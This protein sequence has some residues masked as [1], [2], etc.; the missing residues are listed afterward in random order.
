MVKVL[1]VDDSPVARQF[2]EHVLQTDPNLRVVGKVSSGQEAIDF[3]AR[4]KPDVV[5]M[6]IHMPG[7]DGFEATRRIMEHNPVPIVMVSACYEPGEVDKAFRALDE[8]ALALLARP[9]GIG[10]DRHEEQSRAIC[11]TVR[12]MAGVKV[13]RRMRRT[14]RPVRPLPPPQ[15][16]EAETAA[17]PYQVLAL[18]ASTGGPPVLQT[19]LSGLPWGYPLPVLIVQHIAAGFVHGMVEWLNSTSRLPV[20]VASHQERILPGHAYVAPDSFQMG[21]DAARR[22]VLSAA[23]PEHGVRPSVA[24]LFRSVAEQFGAKALVVLLTGMGKDGASEL[25][26]LRQ[27]GATTFVQNRESCVV[28]G[29]PGEAVRLGAAVHELPPDRI[30]EMLGALA[31]RSR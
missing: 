30:T 20:R 28:F 14:P 11:D 21:V 1:I 27:R 2:L 10:D 18:G 13:V 9:A 7:M 16:A 22:I 8:G 3:V 12:L 24:Y 17:G 25:Q 26:I 5:T 4:A 29:M 15:Q 6:D 31:Y 23:P 19:I